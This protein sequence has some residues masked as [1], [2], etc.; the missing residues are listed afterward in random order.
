MFSETITFTI[1]A[2]ARTLTRINQDKY[3]SEYLL[4]TPNEEFRANIRN[5]SYVDKTRAGTVVDR[6]NVQLI[7]SVYPAVAGQPNLVRKAYIVV[8]NDSRD[9]IT[10]PAKFDAGFVGFLTEANFTKLINWES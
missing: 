2:V 10:D 9:T 6:H 7:H 3:S 1:N 5:T 8:E 4:K